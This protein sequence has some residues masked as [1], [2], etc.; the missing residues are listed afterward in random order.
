M[1]KLEKKDL[2]QF[3]K[4]IAS[5]LKDKATNE[6][7]L[8]YLSTEILVNT[9]GLGWINKNSFIEPGKLTKI[10]R[11]IRKFLKADSA[12]GSLDRFRYQHRIIDLAQLIYNF[13]GIKGFEQKVELIKLGN[14]EDTLAEF[15]CGEGFKRSNTKFEFII[16]QNQKGSDFDIKVLILDKGQHLNCE[17]KAKA[18]NTVLRYETVLKSLKKSQSQLPANEPGMSFLKIPESWIYDQNIATTIGDAIW[19]FFNNTKRV[20]AVVLRWERWGNANK[21]TQVSCAKTYKSYFNEKSKLLTNEIK[22][23]INNIPI[24]NSSDWVR[25]ADIVKDVINSNSD[26][27]L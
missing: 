2:I 16:P 22:K 9:L 14:L 4:E 23:V 17:V 24:Y 8:F 6:L 27:H 1:K 12:Y 3:I 11:E 15:E 19:K 21:N 18:E 5:H 26:R 25:L 13:Q 7:V 20:T 10:S